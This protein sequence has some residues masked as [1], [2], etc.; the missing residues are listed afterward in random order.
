M[1]MSLISS[2]T[3]TGSVGNIQFTSIPQDGSDLYLLLTGRTTSANVV[4]STVFNFNSS[5]TFFTRWLA[6]N[7]TA[8]NNEVLEAGFQ[9]RSGDSATANTFSSMALYIHN[10]TSSTDKFYSGEAVVENNAD[11]SGIFLI[12]GRHAT[13]SPITS[14]LIDGTLLAGSSA[15]L[16]K[17]TKGSDGIVTTS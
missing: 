9:I 12:S 2:V 13:A 15:C 1:T 5:N 8:V 16:Y 11:A 4:S 6:R 14:I 7:T 10:Y 17:I 3:A